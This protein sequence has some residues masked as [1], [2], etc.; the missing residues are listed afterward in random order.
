VKIVNTLWHCFTTTL[1]LVAV[2]LVIAVVLPVGWLKKHTPLGTITRE[3][4]MWWLLV[5]LNALGVG[6]WV[7]VVTTD[8]LRIGSQ[9][10]L[11]AT[12][13]STAGF[14]VLLLLAKNQP[15][16]NQNDNKHSA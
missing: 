3:Q 15:W 4:S 8:Q 9:Q 1:L 11:L 13:F 12:A 10:G 7:Y 2:I 6:V 14:A 5:T 16:R